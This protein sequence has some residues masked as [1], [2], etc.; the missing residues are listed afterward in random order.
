V[1]AP[2]HIMPVANAIESTFATVPTL[3]GLAFKLIEEAEKTWRRTNGP[4]RSISSAWHPIVGDIPCDIENNH[5]AQILSSCAA[6]ERHC[7]TLPR[8]RWPA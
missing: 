6:I 8:I 4:K 3:L 5:R 1:R 7:P 2:A